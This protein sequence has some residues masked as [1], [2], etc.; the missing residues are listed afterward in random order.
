[1]LLIFCQ[2][3]SLQKRLEVTEERLQSERLERAEKLSVIE[4]KL[5]HENAT[6]QVGLILILSKK[7]SQP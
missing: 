1:M 2:L 4:E 3:Q 5:L 6:L 7:E